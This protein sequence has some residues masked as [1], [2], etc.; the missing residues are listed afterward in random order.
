MNADDAKKALEPISVFLKENTSKR[1]LIVGTTAS[2]GQDASCLKLS[3][4][5]A[6]A[7]KNTLIEMGVSNE[8]IETLGLGRKK[9]FLR[10]NDLDVNGKLIENLASQNRAVY[11]FD[12]DSLEAKDIYRIA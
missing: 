12:S 3:L 2:T 9:C 5:R 4:D 8:Q 11:I 7:C 6:E 1:I 10:V